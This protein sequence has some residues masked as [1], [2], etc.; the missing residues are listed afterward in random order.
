MQCGIVYDRRPG[1][2][3]KLARLSSEGRSTAT[4]LVS[5]TSVRQ[6]KEQAKVGLIKPESAKILSFTDNRQ[7]ASLQAGHFNDFVTTVRLRAALRSAVAKHKVLDHSNI[8]SKVVEELQLQQEDYAITPAAG[9]GEKKNREA[10]SS[11]IEYLLYE[12]LR[13]GWRIMQP[14]L[15]Q[16][17]L[18]R[19]DYEG[20]AEICGNA[21]FWAKYHHPVLSKATPEQ[22]YKAC[23]VFLDRLRRE[24]VIDAQ[25]MQEQGIEEMRRKVEQAL[26]E[27]WGFPE[28]T[29]LREAGWAILTLDKKT[30]NEM[31]I[32]L[33]LSS[34]SRLGMFLRSARAWDW[35]EESL[36]KMIT[37]YSCN[38]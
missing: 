5:L 2:F 7:D 17:G 23:R 10:L 36:P 16:A 18:L 14:N 22:R 15:E 33:K 32:K 34:R 21:D 38:G 9:I 20:L 24:L 25:I 13:R 6:L 1:E 26:K 4:T 29:N 31:T 11:Y 3:K 28:G 27:P 30:I 8:V 12:D 35:L 19:V 37:T